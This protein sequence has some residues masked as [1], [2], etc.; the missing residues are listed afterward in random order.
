MDPLFHKNW[1]KLLR[2]NIKSMILRNMNSNL[3]CQIILQDLNTHGKSSGHDSLTHCD[4]NLKLFQVA[5]NES[6][7]ASKPGIAVGGLGKSQYAAKGFLLI[8]ALQG[9]S[10][11]ESRLVVRDGS[12]VFPFPACYQCIVQVS[13]GTK[14]TKYP[15]TFKLS[16]GVFWQDSYIMSHYEIAIIEQ[17]FSCLLLGFSPFQENT[18]TTVQVVNVL[19]SAREVHQATRVSPGSSRRLLATPSSNACISKPSCQYSFKMF[20]D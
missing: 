10:L 8:A 2:T 17:R 20:W 5:V 19:K 15:D 18:E 9:K 13:S 16:K 6:I 3:E 1:S 12:R 4:S 7:N 14:P 11:E